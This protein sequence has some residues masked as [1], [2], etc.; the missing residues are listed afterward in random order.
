[1]KLVWGAVILAAA[2]SCGDNGEDTRV[3]NPVRDSYG[4][5]E[6]HELPG[7]L[8]GNNSQ[9]K[10]WTNY[11]NTSDNL[12]VVLEPGGACW[13]YDS[14]TGVTGVMGAANPD[15]LPD[16][17]YDLA[18]FISPFLNRGDDTSPSIDWNY[19]Y[20]PYCTGDVHTGNATA[21]YEN[22]D[23][24]DGVVFHHDGHSDME[25][26]TAWI[27]SQFT[28]VPKMLVTG[29][30]AGGVG[31]LVNYHM[32]R[33]GVHAADKGYLLDDS[34]PVFPS[35]GYSGLMHAKIRSAW[36][37]D[38]LA[39]QMPSGMDFQDMG[40]INTALADE[41][42]NDRLATTFFRRDDD[43]SLYSYNRFYNYP[44]KDQIMDMWNSDTL[45]LTAEY[46]TRDNLYYFIPYWRN[47]N[48][49]HC[50]TVLNFAGSD[51]EA[52][53]ITLA[54]WIND[55]VGDQPVSS[56]LED[57]VPGEDP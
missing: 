24:T 45:L 37:L 28:H 20:V 36:N 27:D 11:S 4:T 18:P 3:L 38:S 47:I 25:K 26:I 6:K 54:Q 41:F 43:F 51:I 7:T 16:D 2:A 32:L 44:P 10:F 13:D 50:T 14:C 23:N 17:H 15:G 52:Q 21:E 12:V 42:P 5:W 9:Y 1:M 19:V 31:A 22:D 29:C 53:N 46:A 55:F 8:C 57:P 39:S 56:H 33:N 35:S 40:S 49:S 34:G 48:N 30:S